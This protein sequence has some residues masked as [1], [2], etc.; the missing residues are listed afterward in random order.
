MSARVNNTLLAMLVERMDSKFKF[1][2]KNGTVRKAS[3]KLTMWC[4]VLSIDMPPPHWPLGHIT[5]TIIG[6]DGQ[7]SVVNVQ[8]GQK[9]LTRS[10]QKLVLLECDGQINKS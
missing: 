7:V 2:Q 9:E 1:S 4:L 6:S 3:S 10:V 8:V 5:K